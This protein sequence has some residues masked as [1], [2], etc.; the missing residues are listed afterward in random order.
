MAF[1]M[2]RLRVRPMPGLIELKYVRS[3]K[4]E[5][6]KGLVET[7]YAITEGGRKPL[8]DDPRTQNLP[9]LRDKER[10]T[11]LRYA[12]SASIGQEA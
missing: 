12:D 11:N 2:D 10:C 9:E 3:E 7:V 1:E 5:L 8:K 6:E 4:L